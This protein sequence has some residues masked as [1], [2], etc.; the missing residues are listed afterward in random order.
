MTRDLSL[1]R[2]TVPSLTR[3]SMKDEIFNEEYYT[4]CNPKE[5]STVEVEDI[6]DTL[7]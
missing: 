2:A 1:N 3:H 6:Y 5:L 4:T 7:H